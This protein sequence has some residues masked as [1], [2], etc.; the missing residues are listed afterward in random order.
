MANQTTESS[1]QKQFN[2]ENLKDIDT[3]FPNAEDKISDKV[4]LFLDKSENQPYAHTNEGY[5]VIVKMTGAVD[6]T[7]AISEY[8]RKKTELIY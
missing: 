3:L 2:Q 7:D 1:E 4:N 5:V 6:A 8:L